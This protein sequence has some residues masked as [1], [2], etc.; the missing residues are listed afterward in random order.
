MQQFARILRALV[1]DGRWHRSLALAVAFAIGCGLLSWWQFARRQE[2]ADANA[3]ISANASAPAAPLTDLLDSLTAYS[4]TQQWRTVRVEG[5]YLRKQQLLVRNRVDP[6]GDPG[7]E[8]LTPLRTTDGNV[9][10]A[11]RLLGMHRRS[12]QRK[13]AKRPGPERNDSDG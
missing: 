7:F 3:L 8:V 6:D 2:T 4:S 12:L 13:L 1:S 9:S 10:A 11:A 5:T